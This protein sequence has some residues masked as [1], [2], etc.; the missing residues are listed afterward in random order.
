MRSRSITFRPPIPLYEAI[1]KLSKKQGYGNLSK[2][3]IGACIIAILDEHRKGWIPAIAN[4]NPKLQDYMIRQV[5][6]VP[7]EIEGMI[8]TFKNRER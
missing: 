2:F 8:K 1:R 6:E 4:A 7:Q 3:L 5:L